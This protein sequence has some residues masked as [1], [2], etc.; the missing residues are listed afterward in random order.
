MRGFAG[1][2]GIFDFSP[3]DHNGLGIDAFEMLTV[4]DGKFAILGK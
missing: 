4:K 2:A 3:A 1:T